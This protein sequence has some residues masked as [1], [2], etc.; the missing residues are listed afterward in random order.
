M[1]SGRKYNQKNNQSSENQW[2]AEKKKKKNARGTNL[3][4]SPQTEK[5]Q[6]GD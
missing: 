3:G 4:E 1:P 2:K 6:G 5:S